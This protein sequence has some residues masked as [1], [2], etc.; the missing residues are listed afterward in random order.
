MANTLQLCEKY[1]GTQNIYTL[2]NLN[3]DAIEKDGKCSYVGVYVF[4]PH[5]RM[6]SLPENTAGKITI[7]GTH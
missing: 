6:F 7:C 5:F 4:F 3:K 1:F 2:M